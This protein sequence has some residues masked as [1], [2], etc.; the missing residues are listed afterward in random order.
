MKINRNN[1]RAVFNA[2]RK[3]G[4]AL[5]TRKA[6]AADDTLYDAAYDYLALYDGTAPYMLEMQGLVNGG[7]S[8]SNR[9]AALALNNLIRQSERSAK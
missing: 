2:Y 7:E 5:F 9:Q 1:F 8:L 3:N 6:T 4:N